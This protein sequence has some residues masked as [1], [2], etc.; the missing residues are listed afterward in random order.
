[1]GRVDI[2]DY[3]GFPV[4]RE[5]ANGPAI[6]DL[7]NHFP[8]LH[9]LSA[10]VRRYCRKSEEE[11]AVLRKSLF[12]ALR[13]YADDKRLDVGDVWEMCEGRAADR[14]SQQVR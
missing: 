1:M 11:R 7:R 5:V 4:G 6:F 14:G 13:W 9:E 3:G 12:A 2:L 8:T 10:A